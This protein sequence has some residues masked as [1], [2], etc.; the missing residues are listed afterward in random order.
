DANGNIVGWH[1]RMVG[2]SIF[3]RAIPDAF[4]AAKGRDASF[5]DG[6]ELVYDVP[7]FELDYLREQRGV[8]VGFWRAVGAGYTKFAIETMID[9]LAREKKMDPVAYRLELLKKSP[10]ATAVVKAAAEMANWGKPR[11]GRM[12]GIAYADFGPE[13]PIDSP[14]RNH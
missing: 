6:A 7:A 11:E 10:R 1:H 14:M 5:D 12:L 3:A 9:E 8:E 13:L 2:E 4:K